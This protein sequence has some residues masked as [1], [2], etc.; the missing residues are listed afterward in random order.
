MP[1]QPNP[2]DS[3]FS[4]L[5]H[6]PFLFVGSGLSR[7]YMDTP[8]WVALL[9]MFAKKLHP[10][11]PL[12]LE[13]FK[14]GNEDD[15]WPLIATR[16]E[17]EFRSLWLTHADYEEDRK[18][19]VDVVKSGVSPFK[20]CIAK[21]FEE[22]T[23]S[24]EDQHL[25]DE[26]AILNNVAKRS[27]A[28]LITTNYDMLLEGVFKGYTSYIGQEQL[29]FSEP[30]GVA[31]IYKIHGCCSEP[32]S[33]VINAKDYENFNSRNAY[34]AAKLLTVFVEHPIIFLGYSISD[35]NVK[36]ILEAITGC[37]TQEK[38]DLL[39]QR[40][41]FVEYSFD[42]LEEPEISS[43]SV[44]FG[45]E[46][47]IEMTRIKLSD[48]K[49]LYSSLMAQRYQYNPKLLRQLKR[50]IYKLVT[51]N[52]PIDRFA[53]A[54]IEDDSQLESYGVLAGVGVMK[55]GD[56]GH[57][58]PEAHEL[59][60]DVVLDSGEFHIE[61]LV[62]T[63]LKPLHRNHGKS[64][65]LHKFIREYEEET[66]MSAPQVVVDLTFNSLDDYLSDTL[67]KRRNTHPYST[68]DE[69][70]EAADSEERKAELFTNLTTLE[71]NV[72]A[73]GEYL[74]EYLTNHP[75]VLRTGNPNLKTDLRRLI[76]I[77]DWLVYGK[78]KDARN[79]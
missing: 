10:G 50:D 71:D 17:K 33:I 44:N 37:L 72:E 20:L 30:Q 66:K 15:D 27:V 67:I 77:Y 31:E 46:T 68:V 22:A 64:I 62:E 26:L 4:S 21:Y 58:M 70:F 47:S 45:N 14:D 78:R 40:L 60:E 24:N 1:K 5:T 49:D 74:K 57:H 79:T 75:D 6:L 59:F 29:L 56:G 69:L 8:S 18:K 19:Y 9:E 39:K 32:N 53:I 13:V 25:I 36:S 28:G 48:Y 34:L 65:P 7:R 23:P 76:K 3:I 38:L 43:H 73:L 41:I 2:F 51:T 61:S 55:N 52:E 16:I 11:N 42:K 63:A 35:P 12:A 54:D